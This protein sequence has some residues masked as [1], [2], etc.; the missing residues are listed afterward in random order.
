MTDAE[1]TKWESERVGGRKRYVW[2]NTIAWTLVVTASFFLII[3]IVK[4]GDKVFG[5]SGEQPWDQII[6]V[7]VLIGFFVGVA[8][9]ALNDSRWGR[10]EIAYRY[11]ASQS[12]SSGNSVN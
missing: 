4:I 7:P 3:V 6:G 12:R 8:S 1:R 5:L 9:Y 11:A 10:N 2:R